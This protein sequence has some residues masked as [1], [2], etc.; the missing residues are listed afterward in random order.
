[1][2]AIRHA[3]KRKAPPAGFSDIEDD[4]LIFNNKMKDAENAPTTNVSRHQVHWPI[5][6][7]S[8]QRS[9]YVYE[10]YY[11]KE[12]ISKELYDWL[13]KNGYADAMLIAKWKKTGY[14]K[15]KETNFNSTCICRVPKAQMKEDH[16]IECVSCGCRG[17]ASSD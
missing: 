7:I 16:A 5:F 14:E 15:T 1:M 17:C 10:L 4:L 2:P 6:Q 3:S 9:R 13:L 12:A 8:H 11:E